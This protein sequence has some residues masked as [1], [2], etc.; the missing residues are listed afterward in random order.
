MSGGQWT[1]E[2]DCWK[3]SNIEMVKT[4]YGYER[5]CKPT[6][7]GRKVLHA[8]EDYVVRCDAYMPEIPGQ[9]KMEGMNER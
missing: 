1:Y 9:L 8:D 2:C 3:C 6:R 4:Q 5:Y 7:Q